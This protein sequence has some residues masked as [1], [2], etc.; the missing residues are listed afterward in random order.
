M[1][2]GDRFTFTVS[3]PTLPSLRVQRSRD[4]RAWL[5][6]TNVLAPKLPWSFTAQPATESA[7]AY[8]VI[9]P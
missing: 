9:A 3:G 8:R 1:T 2:A 4:L 7:E 5:D 6:V